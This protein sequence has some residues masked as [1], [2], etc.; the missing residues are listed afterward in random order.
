MTMKAISRLMAADW[1]GRSGA[2]F[3]AHRFRCERLPLSIAKICESGIVLNKFENI[4][5]YARV[6]IPLIAAALED[7]IDVR[8]VLK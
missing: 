1:I 2:L 7:A 8:R 6:V 4:G 3:G 5:C